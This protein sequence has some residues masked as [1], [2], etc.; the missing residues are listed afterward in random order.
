MIS[1][2]IEGILKLPL[3][4]TFTKDYLKS[5]LNLYHY[6]IGHVRQGIDFAVLENMHNTRKVAQGNGAH[7]NFFNKPA[8]AVNN[9][10]I[11]GPYLIFK[12]HENT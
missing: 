2:Y 5:L 4:K 12:Q 1:S 8:G 6:S 3:F 10:H 7:F 9:G 11:A